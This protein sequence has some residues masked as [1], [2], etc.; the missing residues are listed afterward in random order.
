MELLM[1]SHSLGFKCKKSFNVKTLTISC[2]L[3]RQSGHRIWVQS[4]AVH[5]CC[6][7]CLLLQ[8]L[9]Q[10]LLMC[11]CEGLWERKKRAWVSLWEN[12]C[13]L[14]LSFSL[15]RLYTLAAQRPRQNS[16]MHIPTY[17]YTHLHWRKNIDSLLY[18]I[19]CSLGHTGIKKVN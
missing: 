11:M 10:H 14:P 3:L 2:N 8:L 13:V 18:C 19:F 15:F 16:Q 12:G 1:G 5:C 17:L 7:C 4:I 9:Q 6:F